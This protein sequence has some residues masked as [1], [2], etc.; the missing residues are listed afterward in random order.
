ML[1]LGDLA[2]AESWK[3]WQLYCETEGAWKY[4]CSRDKP[5]V[6]PDSTGHLVKE[7]SVS[8]V[9]KCPHAGESIEYVIPGGHVQS[10]EYFTIRVINYKGG[11]D[12]GWPIEV[13][14]IVKTGTSEGS[15]GSI[16]VQDVTN[17][18]TICEIDGINSVDWIRVF[19]EDIQNLAMD[20]AVWEIQAKV[21]S[22][23]LWISSVKFDY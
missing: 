13:S 14:A 18:Q 4:L 12:D 1:C 17:N 7:D 16:R 10:N 6:C 3:L 11:P 15:N 21:E 9:Q 23:D 22:G 2:M 5:T 19:T 20:E 8:I